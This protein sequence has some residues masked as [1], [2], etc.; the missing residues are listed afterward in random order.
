ARPYA[1]SA[2]VDAHRRAQRLGH[3]PRSLAAPRPK[4]HNAALLISVS[5]SLRWRVEPRI[6]ILVAEEPP[7][8]ALPSPHLHALEAELQNAPH[9]SPPERPFPRILGCVL[10]G[11]PSE[12]HPGHSR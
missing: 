1:T 7:H 4:P 11:P 9:R 12:G 3:Q 6:R 5:L 2:P 10:P 8:V